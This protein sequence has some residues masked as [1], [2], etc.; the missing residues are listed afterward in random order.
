[1]GTIEHTRMD[2]AAS[3]RQIVQKNCLCIRVMT[4]P[5]T[6]IVPFA[7]DSSSGN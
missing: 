5:A 3:D 6:P 2:M 7:E 1:M 4:T